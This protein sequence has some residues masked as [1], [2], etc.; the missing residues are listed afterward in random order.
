MVGQR[1][2]RRSQPSLPKNRR[3]EAPGQLAD[4]RD[5]RL[6]E[7]AG[8]VQLRGDRRRNVGTHPGPDGPERDRKA[9]EALLRTVVEV[10]LNAP[11][12]GVVSLHDP[13][14]RRADL[15]ELRPQI[16]LEPLVVH[17]QGNRRRHGLHKGR[18]VEQ[19]AVMDDRP[20]GAA[21]TL[22]G[23]ARGPR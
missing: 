4:L 18:I 10:A 23:G 13:H 15:L 6:D 21:V 11:A 1:L 22:Q 14:P 3:I 17:C 8:R 9:H 5:R 2:E 7:V 20:D 16:L 19:R 12:F